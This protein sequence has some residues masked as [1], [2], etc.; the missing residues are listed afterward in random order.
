MNK[1][2]GRE[3]EKEILKQLMA[4]DE[5]EFVAI[6]GRRRVGKT[7]LI[8]EYFKKTQVYFEITGLQAGQLHDQ[9]E[10]FISAFRLQFSKKSVLPA[11]ENWNEALR[12][13]ITEVDKKKTKG[14]LI[15]FFDELPWLAYRKSHFL[16]ALEYFWNS[17]ASKKKNVI[18]IV[19]GSAASWMLENVVHNKGGLHN[20]ITKRIRLLPFTLKETND[21]LKSRK[22]N[23]DQKQVLE[24][25]LV[26]GGVPHYLKQIEKGQ[27]AIQ[28][29]NRIC[30][31]KDG[32][33]VDEFNKLYQSLFEHSGNYINVIRALAKKRI[34]LTRDELLVGTQ[35]KSGGGISKILSALEESG[36]I[37]KIIPFGKKSNVALYKLTDEYSLFYLTWISTAPKGVLNSSKHDYWLQKRAGSSWRSWAGYAF[38]SICQKHVHQIKIGLG[39]SGINTMESNWYYRPA[40]KKEKGA[41]IDLIIDRSDNCITICEM[42]YSDLEFIIDKRYHR[43]LQDKMKIF[44]NATR[45]EKTVFLVMMTTY[46][47]KENQYYEEIVSGQLKM[48]VLF[49]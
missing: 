39:I 20:R 1:I 14:K 29:I 6:Y 41:Q 44:K 43:N 2:I 46:G 15:F 35:M 49:Q 11:P 4:S 16:Q 7:F 22:I 38:E 9:L 3:D 27:S 48:N 45:T 37:S 32:I 25:Y 28:N 10:N 21:Y 8:R 30:F 24:I 33:L 23:L 13:L 12:I 19:C 5:P 47:V 40:D 36:F 42:K 18:V 34:G 31:T 17:W 26:M